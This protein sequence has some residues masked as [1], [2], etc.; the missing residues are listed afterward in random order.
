MLKRV[1]N[2]IWFFVVTGIVFLL[3]LFPLTGIFLMLLVASYWSIALINLGMVMLVVEVLGGR[4]RA[5]SLL[6]LL[7]PA[8]YVIGYG[9]YFI[10]DKE[11]VRARATEVAVHNAALDLTDVSAD[12]ALVVSR[13]VS[14]LKLLAT[15]GP[16]VVYRVNRGMANAPYTS[17]R[18][19]SGETCDF[20]RAAREDHPEAGIIVQRPSVRSRYF[21][22]QLGNNYQDYGRDICEIQLPE[23]PSSGEI[24]VIAASSRR[25]D[26]MRVNEYHLS[27]PNESSQTLIAI[28][29]KRLAPIPMPVMGCALISSSPSWDCAAGFLRT[30]ALEPIDER[31]GIEGSIAAAAGWP[32]A[33]RENWRPADHQEVVDA[34]AQ[35]TAR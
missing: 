27:F 2:A 6:W 20:A 32:E 17:V 31:G 30:G 19:A 5:H 10:A 15:G 25:E 28:R 24:Q 22:Q 7:L 12:K 1:P 26:H 23:S 21:R 3:Q 14:A 34:I 13:D 16:S 11:Q 8:A 33:S 18:M 4:G 29:F 9:A 35:V